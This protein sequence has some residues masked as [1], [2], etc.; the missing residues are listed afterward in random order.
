MGARETADGCTGLP[1]ITRWHEQEDHIWHRPALSHSLSLDPLSLPKH[2]QRKPACSRQRAKATSTSGSLCHVLE[3]KTGLEVVRNKQKTRPFREQKQLILQSFVPSSHLQAMPL[4]LKPAVPSVH[5]SLLLLT[6][7][8]AAGRLFA[9]PRGLDGP[10]DGLGVELGARCRGRGRRERA[11]VRKE[12]RDHPL[13][14][15][16]VAH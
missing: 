16:D 12:E 10:R 1:H 14:Q 3:R 6:A 11:G 5:R 4:Q 7:A 13:G 2:K 9:G 8:A 15:A